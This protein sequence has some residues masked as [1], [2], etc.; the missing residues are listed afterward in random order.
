MSPQLLAKINAAADYDEG[1][2]HALE[3]QEAL[4]QLTSE[5]LQAHLA[6]MGWYPV[7]SKTA[8][9][10]RDHERVMLVVT[11]RGLTT[12]IT[13]QYPAGAHPEVPWHSVNKG[14]LRMLAHRIAGM[15]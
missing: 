3:R 4:K 13:H 7:E 10:Q 9:L 11:D 15:Q 12:R 2:M 1:W 14:H 6:V 5:Q 8:A